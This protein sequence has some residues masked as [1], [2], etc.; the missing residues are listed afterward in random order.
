MAGTA[1]LHAFG[2]LIFTIEQCNAVVVFCQ[3]QRHAIY[4]SGQ[5]NQLAELQ[6]L[7]PI[8]PKNAVAYLKNMAKG[9]DLRLIFKRIYLF[10]NYIG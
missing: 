4:F 9:G 8:G 6:P 10:A 2:Y 5:L 7:Q 1:H 3:R